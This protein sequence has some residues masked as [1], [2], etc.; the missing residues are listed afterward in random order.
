MGW[1]HHL[2]LALA[3]MSQRGYVTACLCQFHLLLCTS[4]ILCTKLTVGRLHYVKF[5]GTAF[6]TNFEA[7]WTSL[8]RHLVSS[9]PTWAR[10]PTGTRISQGLV[11]NSKFFKKSKNFW[12]HGTLFHAIIIFVYCSLNQLAFEFFQ[13]APPL[14]FYFYNNVRDLECLP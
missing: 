14:L 8:S 6:L 10:M 12:A 11:L 1:V 9:L 3:S 13:I 7:V 4:Q 2:N 5:L